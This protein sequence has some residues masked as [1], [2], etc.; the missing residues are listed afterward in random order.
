LFGVVQKLATASV[1]GE[2]SA[3][4]IASAFGSTKKK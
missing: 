4:E 1:D 2:L 3:D